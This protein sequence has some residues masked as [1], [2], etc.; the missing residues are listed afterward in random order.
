MLFLRL[1]FRFIA[2]LTGVSLLG[3]CASAQIDPPSRVARLA[4][5]AGVVN[6]SA[7]GDANWVSAT[8]NR[9]VAIG[10]RL[11]T[12][13]NARAEI[14]LGGAAVRLNGQT[15]ASV[16]NLDDQMAQLQLSQGTLNLRVRQMARDQVFEVD[17]P[18]LVFLVRQP[19]EYRVTVDPDGQVTTLIVRSG[20][21][22]A[23]GLG[24]S[25]V[26]DARQTYRFAGTDLRRYQLI[27][28]PWLDEFDRWAMDR[29]RLLDNSVSAR[30][31]SPDVLGYQ[32]LDAHGTWQVDASYGNVWYPNRVAVGWAPYREGH[33]ALVQPWGWTWIDDA[34]WGFAVSH[35][36]RWAQLG[37]RWAWVPGPNQGRVVYAPALVAFVGG[38]NFQLSISSGIASGAAWFCRKQRE[39]RAARA[40]A[41]TGAGW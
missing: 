32:D 19:G 26:I 39:P 18:N 8:V 30:Y 6:F 7:A 40:S 36:G 9:P 25:F 5:T 14:Q 38:N 35:Y 41:A 27:D 15:S 23:R 3:A 11:R 4:Y 33:W 2:I 22:E 24:G 37:G 16:V 12:D 21:G 34:S 1:R 31:V 29:D 10:D 28:T 20:Q 13:G 17:T